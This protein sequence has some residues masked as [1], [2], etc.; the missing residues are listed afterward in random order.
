MF[1]NCSVRNQLNLSYLQFGAT[2]KKL[3]LFATDFCAIAK[4]S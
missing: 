1:Y 3:F 4:V 2:L